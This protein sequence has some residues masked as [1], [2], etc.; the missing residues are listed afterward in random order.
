MGPKWT[1]YVL[2][3]KPNLLPV[4]FAAFENCLALAIVNHWP[5]NQERVLTCD[6]VVVAVGGRPKELSCE[7]GELAI[8]SD[9]LFSLKRS[10]GRT[11]I[12][13]ASYVALECAGTTQCMPSLCIYVVVSPVYL[14]LLVLLFLS[15]SLCLSGSCLFVTHHLLSICIYLSLPLSLTI[16][17]ADF[18]CSLKETFA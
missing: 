8:T 9:D 10:P 15:L 18:S 3:V 6:K 16:T 2:A 4:A 1:S 7:G 17:F 12:V 13:G 14:Y 11:L 5:T